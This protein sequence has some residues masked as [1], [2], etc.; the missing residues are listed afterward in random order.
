MPGETDEGAPDVDCV[1]RQEEARLIEFHSPE[2]AIAV[3]SW[4]K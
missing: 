1:G 3:S 4:H 2:L